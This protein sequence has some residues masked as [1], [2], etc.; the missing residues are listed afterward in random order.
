MLV[1]SSSCEKEE[2]VETTPT[3]SSFFSNL[4]VT[5]IECDD[6]ACANAETPSGINVSLFLTEIDAVESFAQITNGFTDGEGKIFFSGLSEY[7]GVFIRVDYENQTYISYNSLGVNTTAFHEVIFVPGFSYDS[8]DNLERNQNHISFAVPVVGQRSSYKYYT[9]EDRDFDI[10]DFQEVDLTVRIEG[11]ISDAVYLVSETLSALSDD[12]YA[13]Y[14]LN[15]LN[16]W[17]F[18]SDSI[19]VTP[20]EE[21]ELSSCLLGY[22]YIGSAEGN[23]VALP[24][25]PPL[26]HPLDL[27]DYDDSSSVEWEVNMYMEN[28][29]YVD[30]EYD[31]LYLNQLNL[32]PSNGN[33]QLTIYNQNDGFV[34]FC[35][36]DALAPTGFGW[37]L[38]TE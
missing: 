20:A 22:G 25:N 2:P 32:Q 34:R 5:V 10:T 17:E 3:T 37:V 27:D 11:K 1:L 6:L 28:E 7:S 29:T 15:V 30:K 33:L 36:F 12:Q 38:I 18:T 8:N 14:P 35:G 24:L 26:D 13:E 9:R 4:E 31:L 16:H 21:L 19:I 23:R